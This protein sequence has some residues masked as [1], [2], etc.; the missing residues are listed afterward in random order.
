MKT[1]TR[2][3][4]AAYFAIV[5]FNNFGT[6]N[7]KVSSKVH[8]DSDENEDTLTNA[9][10]DMDA[11][12]N[13]SADPLETI[14]RAFKPSTLTSWRHG[15]EFIKSNE[16]RKR[17]IYLSQEDSTKRSKIINNIQIVINSNDSLPNGNSCKDSG[18][19]NVSVSSKP[20]GKGNIVTEVHLSII[21]NVKPNPEIEDIPVIDS[22]RGV[23]EEKPIFH[24]I[25]TPNPSYLHRHNIP[26]VTKFVC[27][28]V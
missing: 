21:T 18:I 25:S 16:L 1:R 8:L 24:P 11:N 22:F 15:S 6:A 26:Q 20:D 14:S 27:S 28:I 23:G 9:T 3:I 12:L 13:E 7:V 19:C 17:R 4:L 2:T 5:T 10:F